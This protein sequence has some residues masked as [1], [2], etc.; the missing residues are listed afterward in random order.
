MFTKSDILPLGIEHEVQHY[1]A[2]HILSHVIMGDFALKK[3]LAAK[4]PYIRQRVWHKNDN[5]HKPL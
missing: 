5:D 1:R 4:N 3:A 2:D